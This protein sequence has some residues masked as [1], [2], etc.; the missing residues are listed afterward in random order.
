MIR[1]TILSAAAAFAFAGAASADVTRKVDVR[2]AD[3]SNPEHVEVVYADIREAARSACLSANRS[4]TFGG[5]WVPSRKSQR[6]VI[7]SC[8]EEAIEATLAEIDIQALEEE[9]ARFVSREVAMAS[10]AR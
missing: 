9:H 8:I 1:T 4:S 10:P 5:F 3:F 7:D 6:E 2:F